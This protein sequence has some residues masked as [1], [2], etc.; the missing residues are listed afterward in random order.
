MY[1]D[2]E[3][4]QFKQ[5]MSVQDAFGRWSAFFSARMGFLNICIRAD[6]A[7]A[8]PLGLYSSTATHGKIP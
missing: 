6:G 5:L 3:I 7:P 1:V 4:L 8:I 2:D